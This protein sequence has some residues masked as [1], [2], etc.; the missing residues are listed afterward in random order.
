MDRN[1][2]ATQASK[3]VSLRLYLFG[4]LQLED[5][6]RAISLPTRKVEA[7][8]AYLALHPK[9]HTREKLA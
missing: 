2:I 9:V 7:L 1:A 8:L 4:R 6:Q 5:A 3:G